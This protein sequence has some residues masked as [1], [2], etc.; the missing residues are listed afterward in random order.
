M[1]SRNWLSVIAILRFGITQP[2]YVLSKLL[3]GNVNSFMS[4][5]KLFSPRKKIK[6]QMIGPFMVLSVLGKRIIEEVKP[7]QMEN[8]A[9]KDI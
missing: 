4:N 1:S 3:L 9:E 2:Q 6:W 7:F 8:L 5:K